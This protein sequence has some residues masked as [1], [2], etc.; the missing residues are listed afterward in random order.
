MQVTSMP[1]CH[2]PL[3]ALVSGLPAASMPLFAQGYYCVRDAAAAAAAVAVVA[4]V[5]AALL[6]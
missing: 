5:A 2:N 3:H 4:A 1:V 6:L